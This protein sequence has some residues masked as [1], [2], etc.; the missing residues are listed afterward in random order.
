VSDERVVLDFAR[1]PPGQ[2]PVTGEPVAGFFLP[3][4]CKKDPDEKTRMD[5]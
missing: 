3:N 1:A 2:C 5:P 4:A